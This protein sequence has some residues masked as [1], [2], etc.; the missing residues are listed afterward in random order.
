MKTYELVLPDNTP[1]TLQY[2]EANN[3]ITAKVGVQAGGKASNISIPENFTSL[4]NFVQ[5]TANQFHT[6]VST[7]I[8]QVKGRGADAFRGDYQMEIAGGSQTTGASGGSG[9][10]GNTGRS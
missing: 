6:P 9:A 5:E 1:L 7:W 10:S 3:R 2:D 4:Q 8:Q